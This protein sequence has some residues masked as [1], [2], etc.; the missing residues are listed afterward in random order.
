[1]NYHL[2]IGLWDTECAILWWT[3]QWPISSTIFPC[4]WIG[5]SPQC[6]PIL[7]IVFLFGQVH[8]EFNKFIN[9]LFFQSSHKPMFLNVQALHVFLME[10]AIQNA[11]LNDKIN[12]IKDDKSI[13]YYKIVWFKYKFNCYPNLLISY[14]KITR[15]VKSWPH[16]TKCLAAKHSV[17]L[18]NTQINLPSTHFYLSPISYR[19]RAGSFPLAGS[20]DEI[21]LERCSVFWVGWQTMNNLT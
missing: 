19:S 2:A 7:V 11:F 13:I 6:F 5:T 8:V 20:P 15:H 9:I 21:M 12:L 10:K 1:M 16:R 3:R 4:K 17:T 14:K 18:K